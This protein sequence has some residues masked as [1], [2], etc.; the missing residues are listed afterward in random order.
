MQSSKCIYRNRAQQDDFFDANPMG[1]RLKV[2]SH[3]AY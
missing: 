3:A 1:A 2:N